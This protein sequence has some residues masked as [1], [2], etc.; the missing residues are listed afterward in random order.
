MSDELA[1]VRI[2]HAADACDYGS[3][4]T[5]IVVVV[6][7]ARDYADLLERSLADDPAAALLHLR[8]EWH[9]QCLHDIETMT[10]REVRRSVRA[11]WRVLKAA[12]TERECGCDEGYDRE[13]GEPCGNCNAEAG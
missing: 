7:A 2:R 4:G 5:N 9:R 3:G 6:Q 10:A 1:A 8:A 13:F 11:F 12:K